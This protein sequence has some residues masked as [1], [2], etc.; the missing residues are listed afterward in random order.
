MTKSLVKKLLAMAGYEVRRKEK[1]K[2]ESWHYDSTNARECIELIRKDTMVSWAGLLSLFQQALFCEEHGI[3]GSFVECGVWKGGSCGLMALVNLRY[4]SARRPIHLF[5]A[6]QEICEPDAAVDGVRAVSEVKE[7]SRAPG[8]SGQLRPL[9]GFYDS[10]GGPGTLEENKAL[11]EGK[12]GYPGEFLHYHAGWFQDTLPRDASNV[13]PIAILRLDSDWYASTKICLSH[14]YQNVAKG[15]FVIVD[16]YGAYDG[17]R[18]AVD[19]CLERHIPPVFLSC[20]NQ[21]IR[22]WIKP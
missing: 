20:V 1:E 22:Y 7:W 15:G 5:D 3:P 13:G 9:T 21:D 17:C 4:G 2:K 16:D 11:L 10:Q 12:I 19:E 6:F 8:F 14:L 18:K